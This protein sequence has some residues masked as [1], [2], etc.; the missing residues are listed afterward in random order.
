MCRSLS[1]KCACNCDRHAFAWISLDPC[2]CV[3]VCQ[4]ASVCICVLMGVRYTVAGLK[5]SVVKR[6]LG[7]SACFPMKSH[8]LLAVHLEKLSVNR[9]LTQKAGP[10]K[11]L[12]I[13]SGALDA[14]VPLSPSHCA[15]TRTNCIHRPLHKNILGP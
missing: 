15:M 10:L 13:G 9:P 11:T 14:L 12:T 3:F 6:W 5:V 4:C 1:C 8:L 7:D 2:H